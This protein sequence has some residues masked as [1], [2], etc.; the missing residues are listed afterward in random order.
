MIRVLFHSTSI[1]ILVLGVCS[2]FR[3]FKQSLVLETSE[4]LIF[5]QCTAIKKGVES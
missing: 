1:S 4:V 5:L 3:F 2:S